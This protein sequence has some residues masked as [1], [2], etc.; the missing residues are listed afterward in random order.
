MHL[1]IYLWKN[2]SSFFHDNRH[3]DNSVDEWGFLFLIPGASAVA[4]LCK[5]GNSPTAGTRDMT[6][7]I[8]AKWILSHQ[9]VFTSWYG[10]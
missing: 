6:A 5:A 2:L 7:T 9:L 8:R 3:E 10:I 4:H 1:F